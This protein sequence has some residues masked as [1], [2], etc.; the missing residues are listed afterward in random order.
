MF[1]KRQPFS[2]C[3]HL[4]DEP[5]FFSLPEVELKATL[6][7]LRTSASDGKTYRDRCAEFSEEH[8][9][10]FSV[11]KPLPGCPVGRTVLRCF[12]RYRDR[13]YERRFE[14]ACTYRA[15]LL[16][17]RL[18]IRGLAFQQQDLGVSACA[19]T[20]LWSALQRAQE[21]EEGA[22]ATPA[23]ITMRAT[24]YT[25][26]GRAM[27]SEGL[28]LDQMCQAV[29]S[30]G[31]APNLFRAD[32]FEVARA[33]LYSAVLSGISPVLLI[34]RDK[35]S[36]HAV[37]T[38]GMKVRR[39][40]RTS[41]DHVIDDR[42]GD[43]AA[44]YIHD[45][46]YGPYLRA[47]IAKRRGHLLLKIPLRDSEP[48]KTWY[49]THILIPMHVKV[50]MS[51]AEIRKVGIEITKDVHAYRES[52]LQAESSLTSWDSWITRSHRYLEELIAGEHRVPERLVERLARTV[53]LSRYLGVVRVQ[54]DDLDPM[55]FLLDTTT[56][57]RN[58]NC[59][60]VVQLANSRPNTREMAELLALRYD[61]PTFA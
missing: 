38:V 37:A 49:L 25:L 45:D 55:H 9:L 29:R 52:V 1:F 28:S 4:C 26:V 36:H 42:T 51:F 48:P 15:H 31:Y 44:V 34:E 53:P 61:C 17:V 13:N 43:L 5:H 33:L 59:L 46:R 54:A 41:I 14:C 40:R 39:R 50:R 19:T 47:Q 11:I 6:K 18:T 2:A 30:L 3:I 58:L 57:Q 56:T 20:A 21:L 35:E 7:D 24:Q 16:G 12:P 8:Y 23:Q 10:G 27:P 22:P 32:N 60:A